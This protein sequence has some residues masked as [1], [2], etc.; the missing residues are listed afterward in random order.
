MQLWASVD[1][2]RNKA[3]AEVPHHDLQVC[4]YLFNICSLAGTDIQ[5]TV[6]LITRCTPRLLVDRHYNSYYFN[7]FKRLQTPTMSNTEPI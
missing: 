1:V 3:Q 4:R 6:P 2:L 7:T 5:S